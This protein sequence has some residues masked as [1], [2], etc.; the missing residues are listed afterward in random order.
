MTK[1]SPTAK[2]SKIDGVASLVNDKNT[3]HAEDQASVFLAKVGAFTYPTFFTASFDYFATGEGMTIGIVMGTAQNAE[4]VKSLVHEHF[5]TYYGA[6]AEV[7][8][9]LHLP[10]GR[11]GLVPE[12]VQRMISDPTQVIGSFFYAS[13]YHLNHS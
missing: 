7:W 8:P 1:R 12:A 5:G 2:A 10:P 6:G 9:R 4:A 13:R 11:A 3:Q